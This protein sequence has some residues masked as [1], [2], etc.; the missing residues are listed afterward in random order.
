VFKDIALEELKSYPSVQFFQGTVTQIQKR[1]DRTLFHVE[2]QDDK[3]YI[4]EK[5]ILAAGVKEIHPSIANLKN[6][7]GKSIFSCPYCDGW[8]LK[9][10][11]L[12][13][14]AEQEKGVH[15][16]AKL[17]YNWS[18]DLVVATNGNQIS[19]P[20][21]NE[22]EHRN[23]VV[24]TE[25]IKKLHGEGGYLYS[26]E[27]ASGL[28]IRRIGGFIVPEFHRSNSFAEQ[29]GC[30]FKEKGVMVMDGLGRTTQKN[31]YSAG[32]FSQVSPSALI[33][34]AA[35]GSNAAFA[36][37]ADITNERF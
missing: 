32:E 21:K 6:F 11:P 4:A 33:L 9:D 14:V 29:L 26:V 24:V 7:Y 16:M 18:K 20:L 22:L 13:V 25:P 23:I 27:F 31:V 5:I 17:V 19:T 37:N 8:E 3:L 30:E 36:V 2:T 35:D 34:A 1:F 28:E 10:Q 15:H 12:I